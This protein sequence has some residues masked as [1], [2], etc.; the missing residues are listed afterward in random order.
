MDVIETARTTLRPYR[1]SDAESAFGWFGDADVMRLDPGGPDRSIA[2]TAGRL[3][4]YIAHQN[5][6]GF[7]KW[8][9]HAREDGRPIGHAGLMVFG[10]T[11]DVELGFRLLPS[12]WGK[13]LGTEVARAWVGVAR[14]Q[15]G[16]DH[17]IAFTHA[18]NAASLRVMER[19]GMRFTHR[20]RL[21][22]LSS[23]R[24]VETL[25]EAQAGL[26]DVVVFE[27][28]LGVPS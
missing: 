5:E 25:P 2:E 7:S 18:D 3:D 13:G 11:G 12:E 14:K 8:I 28:L 16:L 26:L 27:L 21:T 6:H 22:E 17:I 9:V 1:E 10:R 20:M 19:I 4:R 15:L 23:V 24:T